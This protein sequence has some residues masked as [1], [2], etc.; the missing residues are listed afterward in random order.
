[1]NPL[2]SLFLF[3]LVDI[4]GFSIVLPLFPYLSKQ[5]GM[6]PTQIGLLQTSNA[7]A[8]LFAVP[9]IGILSDKYGRRPLLL[10]CLMGTFTSFVILWQAT[11]PF[12]LFFSRILDGLLGGNISLAQAVVADITS[13]EQ[14]AK[15]MGLLY[16]AFGLGFILGP[17]I[18]GTVVHIRPHLPTLIAAVLSLL[19]LISVYF[20]LPES[21]SLQKRLKSSPSDFIPS[22]S[23]LY[24][25]IKQFRL[26]NILWI[27]FLY[28]TEFTLFETTFGFY[29]LHILQL[30]ARWSSYLLVLY[31]IVYSAVQGGG[32]RVLTKKYTLESLLWRGFA[33]LTV[34]YFISSRTVSLLQQA[35]VVIPLSLASGVC[36]TIISTLVSQEVDPALYGGALGL[37]AAIGSLTRVMAPAMGGVLVEY[38]GPHT[39]GYCCSGICLYLTF[40]ALNLCKYSTTENPSNEN[41]AANTVNDTQSERRHFSVSAVFVF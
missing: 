27:R 22:V 26:R 7:L 12:W 3:V 28:L 17:A 5:Y 23:S 19:N 40:L 33:M 25:C 13:K 4:L 41:G 36:N 15:G 24:R 6:T 34:F 37:S 8:Q 39:P 10:V 38:L 9:I 1:M 21:L 35:L 31:G 2:V 20:F 11:T 18:G 16:A 29:N 14:R 30:N 32:I